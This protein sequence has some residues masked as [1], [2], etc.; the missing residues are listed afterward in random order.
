MYHSSSISPFLSK[1]AAAQLNS[2][3]DIGS[4]FIVEDDG[5][6]IF[7]LFSFISWHGIIV[8]DDHTSD[9]DFWETA[10]VVSILVFLV[11]AGN[12]NS[13]NMGNKEFKDGFFSVMMESVYVSFLL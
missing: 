13:D 11:F 12:I 8:G 3:N 10:A 6:D 7:G 9:D 2:S 1:S 4:V 5:V